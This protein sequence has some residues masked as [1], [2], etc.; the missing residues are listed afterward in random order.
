MNRA[1]QQDTGVGRE[2]QRICPH[3]KSTVEMQ[4]NHIVRICAQRG[5]VLA[6][7]VV[8]CG[9]A[10]GQ[11]GAAHAVHDDRICVLV[12]NQRR[13][14]IIL[15]GGAD[16]GLVSDDIVGRAAAREIDRVAGGEQI[17]DEIIAGTSGTDS[18]GR[19]AAH[20]VGN[21]HAL[22]SPGMNAD[23]VVVT[24]VVSHDV[25]VAAGDINARRVVMARVVGDVGPRGGNLDS[26][27]IIMTVVVEHGRLGGILN[28]D[29]R[30]AISR[31]VGAGDCHFIVKGRVAVSI[32]ENA[33]QSEVLDHY[34]VDVHPARRRSEDALDVC[35][36]AIKRSTGY[37]HV[38]RT[39]RNGDQGHGH[40]EVCRLDHRALSHQTL[41][42]TE[43]K[44]GAAH[45]ID[46]APQQMNNNNVAGIDATGI[47]NRGLE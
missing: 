10:D 26:S 44:S 19:I 36:L 46:S 31:H 22:G 3:S 35:S 29:A 12:I 24:G 32:Q 21:D 47:V 20:R 28:V 6:L 37:R 39:R 27:P 18:R 2:L 40:G 11:I 9:R 17:V 45:G 25:I 14:E 8:N 16:R 43:H 42:R 41:V 13:I 23:A 4:D 30:R 38:G 1:I 33:I 7:H 15:S 5:V 34:L